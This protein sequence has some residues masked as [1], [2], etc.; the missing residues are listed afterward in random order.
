MVLVGVLVSRH[1]IPLRD[2]WRFTLGEYMAVTDLDAYINA[3][4]PDGWDKEK[5]ADFEAHLRKKGIL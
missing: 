3:K 4:K 5:I 2:A 1:G